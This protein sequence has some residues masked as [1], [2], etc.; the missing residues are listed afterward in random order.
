MSIEKMLQEREG[1]YGKFENHAAICQAMKDV[2]HGSQGWARLNAAQRE[3]FEMILHKLARVLNGDPNY[4]DNWADIAGYAQLVIKHGESLAERAAAHLNRMEP[5]QR[6]MPG[7]AT[8][9]YFRWLAE[10]SNVYKIDP[11]SYHV[12]M[13]RC[14]VSFTDW[15]A[16]VRLSARQV[17]AARKAWGILLQ[18][19]LIAKEALTNKFKTD[20]AQEGAAIVWEAWQK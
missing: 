14:A 15:S 3:S 17:V 18:D 8:R 5:V 1:R 19:P 7:V 11:D 13:D 6:E 9:A 4:S 20:S 12:W 16:G 10:S 2:A